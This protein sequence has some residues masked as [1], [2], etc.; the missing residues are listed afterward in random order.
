ME[1]TFE[2]VSSVEADISVIENDIA[3]AEGR[4][5]RLDEEIQGARYEEQVRERSAAIRQKEADRDKI[6]SDLAVLNRQA[7]SRAQLSIKRSDYDSK[8]SQMNA[9]MQSHAVRFKE[10]VGSD[11]EA[12]TMEEAVT[13]AA[14]RKDRELQEAETASAANDRSLSQ[15]QTS[16]HIAKQTLRTKKEELGRLERIIAEALEESGKSSIEDA[17]SEAQ[18]EVNVRN[19]EINDKENSMKFYNRVLD[20]GRMKK[21]CIGCDRAIH[22]NE[23]NS[24]E[25]Y[26]T[27]RIERVSSDNTAELQEELEQWQGE[28]DKLRA[29]QPSVEIAKALKEREIPAL[30]QQIAAE[31]TKLEQAQKD[32]EESK[33]KLQTAKLASR[34]LQT[35][36]S[37]AVI[38]SRTATDLKDLESDIQRLERDLQSTG[39]L[40]TVDDVQREV[41]Q[42]T[43]EIKALQRE[44]QQ[45]SSEKELKVNTLR[46]LSEEL[47]RKTLRL[48][49]LRSKQSKRRMDEAALKEQQEQVT[50]MQKEL[51][52]LDAKAASAVAPWREKNEAIERH[53]RDRINSEGEA[54]HQ[55]D[56]Y[57]SSL[58]EVQGK[59]EA[60]QMYIAEGTDRKIRE[61]ETHITEIRQ[62]IINLHKGRDKIAAELAAINQNIAQGSSERRNIKANIDYRA[63]EELIRQTEEEIESLDIDSAETARREFNSKYKVNLDLET[64]VQAQWQLAS[65]I[66]L[67]MTEDRKLKEKTLKVEYKDIDKQ[68][69]EQLIKTKVSER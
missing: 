20:M 68:F 55:V 9:S 65:G 7:D 52:E 46:S 17:L 39:S 15:L 61:N 12:E 64:K 45:L 63:N 47:G 26:I 16:V 54:A 67:Q 8:T 13:T 43:S 53:R 49:E 34:D 66:L 48:G 50:L 69:K 28:L 40:K 14:S 59:H 41:D 31:T 42:I 62:E 4:R 2:S 58:S 23:K 56:V 33:Q 6:S 29:A 51:R 10:L 24:F 25:A 18:T 1:A 22:A 60:C 5:D 11:I 57:R 21:K 27:T 30:E 36:K 32:L 3:V 37:A 38:I 19:E 44:Q 35:L